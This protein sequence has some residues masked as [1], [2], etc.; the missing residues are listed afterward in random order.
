[1]ALKFTSKILLAK[2]ETSY[3]VDPTPSGAA[4]AILATNVVLSPMEGND[5]S[6]DLETPYLG[7]QATIPTELHMKISFKVELQGGGTAGTPPGW[8]P[9]LRAC[10]VAETVAAGT[11]VTYNP[12]TDSHESIALHLWIDGTRYVLLGG[13]GSCKINVTAQAIPYLEFEFQG[14]FTQPGEQARPTPTLTGFQKP[15]VATKANTPTFTI[16][17]SNFTMRSFKLDLGNKIENRFLI[18]SESVLIT[19]RADMI[20]TSVE[21]T[22]LTT[23]NPFTQAA[24][25]SAVPVKLVHGTTAG[26]IAT[27]NAPTAQL[28][29]LQS[30]ENQQGVLEWPLRMVPL[31]TSGNDQWTLVLT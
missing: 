23:F 17:G 9:L 27:L 12:I 21:A 24:A 18:G 15:S 2:I 30:L 16:A 7:A 22:L 28:Q 26:K 13:R 29:R 14:F 19:D 4:N 25:Q 1:M 20:E 6:R 3:G 31:P 10:A 5:V 11:S 8:G